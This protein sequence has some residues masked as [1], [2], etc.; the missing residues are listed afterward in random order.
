MEQAA[1]NSFR[2]ASIF[3]P[4]IPVPRRFPST[5]TSLLDV[6]VCTEDFLGREIQGAEASAEKEERGTEVATEVT[7]AGA[8]ELAAN[9]CCAGAGKDWEG[10]RSAWTEAWVV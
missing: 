4:P 5:F 3:P 1:W 10:G 8:A 7:I 2:K 6:G 9:D